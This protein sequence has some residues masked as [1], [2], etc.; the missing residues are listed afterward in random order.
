M[1]AS[2][3]Q[4]KSLTLANTTEEQFANDFFHEG[5]HVVSISKNGRRRGQK[6]IL[7]GMLDQE[8]KQWKVC[9]ESDGVI[10][11]YHIR[12]LQRIQTVDESEKEEI[13]GELFFCRICES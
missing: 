5:D 2:G 6:G 13:I 3:D 10:K 11:E 9:W 8:T 12:K 1:T 4:Q 7:V